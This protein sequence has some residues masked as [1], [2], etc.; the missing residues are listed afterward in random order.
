MKTKVVEHTLPQLKKQ[1]QWSGPTLKKKAYSYQIEAARK[2]IQKQKLGLWM[3]QGTGKT[4]V[5]LRV[6][7]LLWKKG[8][9]NSVLVLAPKVVL[10]VWEKEIKDTLLCPY[11]IDINGDGIQFDLL[12]YERLRN[13]KDKKKRRVKYDLVI[14]DESH[15]IKNRNSIQSKVAAKFSENAPYVLA[16]SGTPRGNEDVDFYAQYRF[17]N[18]SLFGT[19]KEFDKEYLKPCGYMGYKRKLRPLK[20]KKFYQIIHENSYRITKDECFELP[21]ITETTIP[22]ELVNR[23][24]YDKL[25]ADLVIKFKSQ[26]DIITIEAPLAITLASKLQ[27]LASGFIYDEQH[28]IIPTDDSKVKA[29]KELLSD[30][31][32]RV[33]IFCKYTYEI[34]LIYKELA[35]LYKILVYDGRTKDKSAWK[36]FSQYDIFLAQIKSGGTGLNLQNESSTVIFYSLTFS[37]IDTS[38]AKDRVY[39][40]G[41]KEKVSVYYLVAKDTI[42]EDILDRVNNKKEGAKEVL[43]SVL[44][45]ALRL[46]TS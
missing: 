44:Y 19:W 16:L 29:L 40:Y 20:A 12:N 38:Q 26:E 6:A 39:R 24:P 28:N 25:L 2:A 11:S 4:L 36:Q 14:A 37:Y 7:T 41:Q 3:E 15:R 9:V 5:A 13:Y 31:K 46:P 30:I 35:D 23:A 43:D 10:S 33:I 34:D 42:E 17:I 45:R 8:L 1:T 27:Q 21:G 18:P 32:G 22:V